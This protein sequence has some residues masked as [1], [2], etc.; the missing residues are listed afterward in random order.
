MNSESEGPIGKKSLNL[1]FVSCISRN[2]K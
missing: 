2:L 1:L